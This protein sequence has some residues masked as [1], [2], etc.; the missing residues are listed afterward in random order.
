MW[1][2]DAWHLILSLHAEDLV[3]YDKVLTKS[4]LSVPETGALATTPN[5]LV[6][7]NANGVLPVNVSGNA[8]Q[9]AGVNVEINRLQDGQVLTFRT[10]SNVWRNED[11]GTVGAG[12]ALTLKDGATLLGEFSGD[13]AVSVDVGSAADTHIAAH[14]TN[15]AAHPDIRGIS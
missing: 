7:L 1:L 10:A 8:G 12:K 6:P 3:G 4:D 11:K 2:S 15:S 13:K 5:K 14:N 9:L